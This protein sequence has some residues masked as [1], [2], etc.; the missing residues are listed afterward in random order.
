ME[1]ARALLCHS[2]LVWA[3]ITYF[4]QALLLSNGKKYANI[5]GLLWKLKYNGVYKALTTVPAI[6]EGA[7]ND[8]YSHY[9]FYIILHHMDIQWKYYYRLYLYGNKDKWI[10]NSSGSVSFVYIILKF[11]KMRKIKC[12]G[13]LAS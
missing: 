7:I 6:Q 5:I 3:W 10:Y 4:T 13:D 1:G 8:I 11:F 9:P 2:V 12:L